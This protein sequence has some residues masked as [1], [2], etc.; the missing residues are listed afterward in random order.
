MYIE[1]YPGK[2]QDCVEIWHSPAED[3]LIEVLRGEIESLPCVR[4]VHHVHY[5]ADVLA[6][7]HSLPGTICLYV[8]GMDGIAMCDAV[9]GV[10]DAII[11]AAHS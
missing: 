11:V 4:I 9:K 10:C 2:F 1:A 3:D 5:G 8:F 6:P 7:L